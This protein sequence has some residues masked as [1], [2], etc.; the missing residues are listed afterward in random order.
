MIINITPAG[1]VESTIMYGVV[2]TFWMLIKK[3]G[4]FTYKE[5]RIERNKI[6]GH[7]VKAGHKSRLKHCPD[8]ICLKLRMP[9]LAQQ[10]HLGPH[11]KS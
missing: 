4:G 3:L 8:L 2:H 9:G 1:V 6:I 11:T 10:G 7:H 5:V